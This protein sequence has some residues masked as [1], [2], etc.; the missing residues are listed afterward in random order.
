[1]NEDKIIP[2]YTILVEKEDKGGFSGSCLELPA[3]ISQGETLEELEKN[4]KDA[5]GLVLQDNLIESK[6]K[7]ILKITI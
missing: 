4:M 1:M 6:H 3:A 7:Q 5:I 2:S